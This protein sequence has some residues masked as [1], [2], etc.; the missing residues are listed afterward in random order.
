MNPSLRS[1]SDIV[2]KRKAKFTSKIVESEVGDEQPSE[3]TFDNEDVFQNSKTYDFKKAKSSNQVTQE[4]KSISEI[5]VFNNQNPNQPISNQHKTSKQGSEAEPDFDD[6]FGGAPKDN[7]FGNSRQNNGD[8]DP[9]AMGDPNS[10]RN[11]P[12]PD[13]DPF[14]VVNASNRSKSGKKNSH[15]AG[16]NDPDFEFDLGAADDS[17][18]KNSRNQN[19]FK[20]Q[21]SNR[22]G[23]GDSSNFNPE[24][25]FSE[26]NRTL[27]NARDPFEDG[28]F[29]QNNE[30]GDQFGNATPKRGFDVKQ[31]QEQDV[32]G[33]AGRNDSQ[34]VALTVHA[35]DGS[36][37]K[38]EVDDFGNQ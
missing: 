16:R 26:N 38:F 4:E 33:Q 17:M 23:D 8:L 20:N 21:D 25:L 30:F 28:G 35:E 3:G 14:A 12:D 6:M 32:F 24:G 13:I 7:S 18:S 11:A 27:E 10:Q 9:F 19:Q 1:K 29:H 36:S 37:K 22:K 2:L 5:D 15:N 34:S 31:G